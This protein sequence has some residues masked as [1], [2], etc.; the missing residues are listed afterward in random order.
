M[1][2]KVNDNKSVSPYLLFFLINGTQT[3]V[4]VLKYQSD[5]LKGAG[6]NA[7]ISVL[8]FGLSL[9]VIFFMMLYVLKQ[10]S[11]GDILSFHLEV[12]GKIFGGIFNIILACYFSLAS[13][14]TLYTY[15]EILQIW[16][17]DGIANWEYTLLLSLLI[18]YIVSGGFRVVT[19]IAFWGVIIP[20]FLFLS[21]L[22]LTNYIDVSY[23]F[24]LFQNQLKDYFISTKEAA[25]MFLGFETVLVYFSFIKNR[26]K[27]TKWGHFSLL[28]T[29]L[30]YTFLAVFTFMFFS[31]G[32]LQRLEWPTLTM[33]KIIQFPFLERFEFIFIFTWLLVVMPVICVYLW[34]AIRCIKM[35]IPKIKSTYILLGLLIVFFIANIQFIDVKYNNLMHKMVLF[36]G[37]AFLFCYVPI[38]FV[39]SIVRKKFKHH[40]S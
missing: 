29:T 14:Y 32:K 37:F 9:H 30:L 22:Y 39:I 28:Y 35:T 36:S 16:V 23:I 10:S 15:I 13:F 4:S 21:I 33:I 24:P 31:Q 12:F 18:F 8:A 6:H 7:W 34:S 1:N 19:G 3:G 40:G 27:A 2:S 17:F 26:D 5:I 11:T 38:L 20:S 25:P